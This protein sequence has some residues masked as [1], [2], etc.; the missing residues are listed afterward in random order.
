MCVGLFREL[1]PGNALMK[2]VTISDYIV[3]SLGIRVSKTLVTR[4]LDNIVTC[5]S[6]YRLG[7]D[8]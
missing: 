2:S 5:F 8:W 1:L 7:S 6:D 4:R 3:V